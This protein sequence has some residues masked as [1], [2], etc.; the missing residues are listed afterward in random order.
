MAQSLYT[1]MTGMRTQQ[2]NIDMIAN[3]V[4]NINT[5]GYKSGR[6]SFEDAAYQAVKGAENGQ[7]GQ[8][9]TI[10]RGSGNLV[11]STIK[12]MSD[13]S[14][15]ETGRNLDVAL[16]GNAFFRVE[17]SDGS[18]GYTRSGNF[19]SQVKD[20]L[21]YLATGDGRF[22]TDANGSRISS[23]SSFEQ[24]SIDAAG[25]IGLDGKVIASLGIFSFA[26]PT[27]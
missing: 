11:A 13:G 17:N 27:D 25:K 10:Q 19:Q 18:F 14:L 8:Q 3:N 12:D 16:S 1:A 6:V 23:E 9:V 4:A 5:V 21:S 26:I 20:G 15:I 2:Q 22:V 24:A 7:E